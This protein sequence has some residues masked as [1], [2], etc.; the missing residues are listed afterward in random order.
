MFPLPLYHMLCHLVVF[1]LYLCR[2]YEGGEMWH[3]H[4]HSHC[5][6]HPSIQCMY[7]L[8][9]ICPCFFSVWSDLSLKDL[10]AWCPPALKDCSCKTD[11]PLCLLLKSGAFQRGLQMCMVSRGCYLSHSLTTNWIVLNCFS[12]PC[13]WFWHKIKHYSACFPVSCC[14]PH[15]IWPLVWLVQYLASDSVQNHRLLIWGSPGLPSCTALGWEG[16]GEREPLAWSQWVVISC[17]EAY[18]S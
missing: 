2:A 1:G 12:D 5:A 4:G 8:E 10:V 18:E 14:L 16:G 7:C 3:H 9:M 11:A 17:P 15:Q 6:C 13:N